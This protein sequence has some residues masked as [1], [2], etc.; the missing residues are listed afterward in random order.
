MDAI[1]RAIPTPQI[2]VIVQGRA[3][4]ANPL[5]LPATD[6]QSTDVHQ[7]IHHLAHHHRAVVAAGAC[8]AGSTVRPDPIRRR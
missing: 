4:P 8:P 6:S 2:E 1:E 5:G 3:R 7:A